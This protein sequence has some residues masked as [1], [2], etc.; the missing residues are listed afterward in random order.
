MNLVAKEFMAANQGRGALVLSR[1]AGAAA[2][3]E[4]GALLVDPRDVGC[5]AAALRRALAMPSAER[6]W[7]LRITQAHLREHDVHH[8]AASFLGALEGDEGLRDESASALTSSVVSTRS[9]GSA[10]H[11]ARAWALHP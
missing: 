4:P 9:R 1:F 11:G 6:V 8:W 7:R 2:E 3:L 10:C 5:V